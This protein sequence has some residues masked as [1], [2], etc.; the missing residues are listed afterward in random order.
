MDCM[1]RAVTVIPSR[2]H[3]VAKARA[4]RKSILLRQ[5]FNLGGVMMRGMG[6]QP[7]RTYA[8]FA[9]CYGV[10][11]V[12]RSSHHDWDADRDILRGSQTAV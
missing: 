1:S 9:S 10:D 3:A 2:F 7:E 5:D 8:D 4:W 12:E 11:D 6:A